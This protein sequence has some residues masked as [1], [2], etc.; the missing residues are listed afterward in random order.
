MILTHFDGQQAELYREERLQAAS[1]HQR[2]KAAREKRG[3]RRRGSRYSR[4]LRM[5]VAKVS[6]LMLVGLLLTVTTP[7]V[8]L[9]Q[10]ILSRRRLSHRR[11][12]MVGTAE[13]PLSHEARPRNRADSPNTP[14]RTA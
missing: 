12:E 5:A 3:R 13:A 9:Q 7:I 2:V 6:T 10:F 1:R 11:F 14:R 8:V 4:Q